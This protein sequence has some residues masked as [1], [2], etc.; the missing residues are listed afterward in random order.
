MSKKDYRVRN[1]DE[2]HEMQR[3]VDRLLR[4]WDS[5]DEYLREHGLEDDEMALVLSRVLEDPS[6]AHPG[7]FLEA[8]AALRANRRTNGTIWQRFL[9]TGVLTYQDVCAAIRAA[10]RHLHTDYDEKRRK[11]GLLPHEIDQL[12]RWAN[13]HG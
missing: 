2:E 6:K 9:D 8:C 11:E 4:R 5:W 13:G 7:W 10:R 1:P 12:K 3:A